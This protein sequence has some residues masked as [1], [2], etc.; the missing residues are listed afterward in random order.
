MFNPD[1]SDIVK[2]IDTGKGDGIEIEIIEYEYLAEIYNPHLLTK[3]KKLRQVRVHLSGGELIAE[4]G[5]L[6][7]M[8]GSVKMKVNNSIA[9]AAKGFFES[10]A[11]GETS[12]KPQYSGT[13]EIY[14]EPSY[15]HYLMFDMDDEEVVADRG[16]FFCCEASITVGVHTNNIV[17]SALGKEGLFQTS[18]KGKGLAVV[19][20][21]VPFSQVLVYQ[22]N[23]ETLQV[24]G[25]Y[26]I[27]RRGKI[28][29]SIEKSTKSLLGSARSGEGFLY[30]YRGTGEVWLI[31]SL[32]Y[33]SN[34]EPII[35]N[36]K[37]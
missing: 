6:Q 28:D 2:V 5:A 16:I 20:S 1:L 24:D 23:D 14:L 30:S 37:P 9:G 19:E 27:L 13:G 32:R 29:F 10:L 35:F 12:V 4:A 7:F 11:T 22:L 33:V 36:P 31:P 3:H 25:N 34:D 18:L 21:P 26:A 17:A 8:K 15:K